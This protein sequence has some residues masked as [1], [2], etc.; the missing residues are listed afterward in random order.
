M[1][2]LDWLVDARHKRNSKPLTRANTL[3]VIRMEMDMFASDLCK[4][5]S[6][7]TSSESTGNRE[8]VAKSIGSSPQDQVKMT[9][10]K[11][12]AIMK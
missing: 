2:E 10:R 6:R 7:K 5:P 1:L 4:S 12:H 11:K 3:L 9:K 8:E